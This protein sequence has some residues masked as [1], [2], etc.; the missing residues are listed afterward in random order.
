MGKKHGCCQS[1]YELKMLNHDSWFTLLQ[2]L[3]FMQRNKFKFHSS[4]IVLP[5]S[6]LFSLFILLCEKWSWEKIWNGSNRSGNDKSCR[7]AVPNQKS[8]VDGRKIGFDDPLFSCST[9]PRCLSRQ[10]EKINSVRRYS[11]LDQTWGS[12]LGMFLIYWFVHRKEI[13]AQSKDIKAFIIRKC[14]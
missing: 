14:I 10:I 8:S 3:W 9:T 5:G 13:I 12:L 11:Q 4:R 2:S 1:S 7:K 6:L